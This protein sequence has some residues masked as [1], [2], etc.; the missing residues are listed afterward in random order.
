[1]KAIVVHQDHTRNIEDIAVPKLNKGEVLLKITYTGICGSDLFHLSGDNPRAEY[2]LVAGHE[3]SGTISKIHSSVTNWEMGDRVTVFPAL[4]CGICEACRS[5]NPQMH[6]PLRMIGVQVPG[7]FADY[8]KVPAENLI[9][10]PTNLDMRKAALAEPLAVAVHGIRLG[11]VE[12]G[13]HALVI[14]AGP[15]GIL[16]A[17]VLKKSGCSTVQ[18]SELSSDRISFARKLGLECIDLSMENAFEAVMS[19]TDGRGADCIFE[20]VGHPSTIPQIIE[21]GALY[22]RAVIIG[23]FHGDGAMVDLFSMSKKEQTLHVS[24]QYRLDDFRR[25]IGLLSEDIL[26]VDRLITH[27]LPPEEIDNGLEMMRSGEAMKVLV[28]FS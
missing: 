28:D 2:P 6:R 10:I 7:G 14:G 9:R 25:A 3:I 12:T 17:L 13:D 21:A 5:G 16:T 1:M 19:R 4:S 24:W 27:I 11:N 15:I 18:L 22:S 8:C 23:A 20:C 26:P